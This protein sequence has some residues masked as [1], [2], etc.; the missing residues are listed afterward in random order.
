MMC[1]VASRDAHDSCVSFW[2]NIQ[3]T[4]WAIF[5]TDF[6]ATL[7]MITKHTQNYRLAFRM[8]NE[9]RR[10]YW[11][12]HG[13]SIHYLGIVVVWCWC[14]RDTGCGIIKPRKNHLKCSYPPSVECCRVFADVLRRSVFHCVL[15][16]PT[17]GKVPDRVLFAS[18]QSFI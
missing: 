14:W 9:R 5:K 15:R 6:I 12:V 4:F 1:G 3:I 17:T 10:Q 13:H 18:S 7:I 11:L 16:S 8:E 2:R